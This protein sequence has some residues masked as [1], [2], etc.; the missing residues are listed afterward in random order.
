M[1]QP[2]RPD[3]T[4]PQHTHLCSIYEPLVF[5][6]RGTA[7]IATSEV[8][9]SYQN[10]NGLTRRR[11]CTRLSVLCKLGID[12][13][14]LAARGSDIIMFS[15][16]RVHTFDLCFHCMRSTAVYKKVSQSLHGVAIQSS[17]GRGADYTMG[18]M[19]VASRYLKHRCPNLNS[20]FLHMRHRPHCVPQD[21]QGHRP[22]LLKNLIGAAASWHIRDIYLRT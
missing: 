6:S 12:V 16:A 11:S 22:R 18:S 17:M 2:E 14:L 21:T 15:G 13:I 3:T 20:Y 8:P 1:M 5:Y 4:D 7:T 19:M 9:R 10:W